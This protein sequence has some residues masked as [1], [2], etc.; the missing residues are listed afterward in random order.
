MTANTQ[1][2]PQP[3]PLMDPTGQP[4]SLMSLIGQNAQPPPT[5]LMS[6]IGQAQPPPPPGPKPL[7]PSAS[8]STNNNEQISSLSHFNDSVQHFVQKIEN[9]PPGSKI[10]HPD[11]DISLVTQFFILCF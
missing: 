2:P 3:Q 5:S 11:D 6:L 4:Q 8:S 10:I 9:A 7:F 1:A